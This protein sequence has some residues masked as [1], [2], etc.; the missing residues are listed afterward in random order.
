MRA[1][2]PI[3]LKSEEEIRILRSAGAVLREVRELICEQVK[4][5]VTTRQLDRLAKKMLDERDV[6]PAFLGYQGF[7]A[8]LCTS[9]NEEIVHGI[10]SDRVLIEG[11]ILSVD[12]GLIKEGFYV[13]TAKTVPVG[14]VDAASMHLI[15]VT[16]KALE[17][18][19][20][21]LYPGNRLGDLSA[22]VQEYVESEGL[23]VVRE[24]AGHGIGR[25]LHEEPRIPNHGSAGR[26][27]RWQAGMVVAVEPM[28]NI[29]THG[30]RTLEDHWTVVTADAE[31]SAHAEH[32][33][34]ITAEG[35]LIL[36]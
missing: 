19:I 20:S 12:F 7:P 2:Q 22:A 30:T 36:T 23:S 33:V 3:E 17:V 28:V 25:R 18:A 32:S 21:Q 6:M 9:V 29:G 13:D 11:D 26:G 10:P 16:E 35:P 24:Y 31:R 15:S 27:I 34:A 14:R 4:P 1:T 8:T 5:G